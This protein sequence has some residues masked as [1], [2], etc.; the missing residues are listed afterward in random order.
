MSEREKE[1]DDGRKD[2]LLCAAKNNSGTVASV[3]VHGCDVTKITK[4][5]KKT[6]KWTSAGVS[7]REVAALEDTKW[8]FCFFFVQTV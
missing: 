5:T 6:P 2:Q 3:S 8:R 1:L 4:Q 7:G